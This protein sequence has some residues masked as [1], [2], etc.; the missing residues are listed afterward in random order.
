MPWSSDLVA[1]GQMRDGLAGFGEGP[2][3]VAGAVYPQYRQIALADIEKPV[4]FV[5]GN[6]RRIVGAQDRRHAV[7]GTFGLA[8]QDGHLFAAIMAVH[9]RAGPGREDGRAGSEYR[10]FGIGLSDQ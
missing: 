10:A 3:H 9:R 7:D 6:E 2:G 5:G 4:G 1:D 8:F